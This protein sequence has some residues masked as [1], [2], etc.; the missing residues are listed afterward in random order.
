MQELHRRQ[1]AVEDVG[2]GD[3]VALLEQLQQAAQ[4]QGLTS[5]DLAGQHHEALVPAHAVIQR[6]QRLIMSGRSEQERRIGDDLER[7]PLQIV[8]SSVHGP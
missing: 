6:R 8:E 4:Q 1:P 7:P 5:A 3:V 2:V